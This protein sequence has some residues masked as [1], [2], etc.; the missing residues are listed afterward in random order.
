MGDVPALHRAAERAGVPDLVVVAPGLSR[1][2]LATLEAGSHG[3]VFPAI[4]EATG[5][6]VIEALAT[7]VPVVASR[8]GPL[9][10]LVG[11]AG[12]LVEPRDV[13]RLAAA[14]RAIWAAD[15][16]HAQLARTALSRAEVS[17]RTWA[18]VARETRMV[19]AEAAGLTDEPD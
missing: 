9:P 18:D 10:E 5:T 11:P 15:H 13:G 16:I 3:F 17:R 14:L 2:D 7:G 19:Y 8:V 4:S 1:E 6:R 12:I